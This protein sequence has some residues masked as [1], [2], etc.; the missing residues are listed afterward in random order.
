[1]SI[2]IVD[3]SRD[4][5][6]LLERIL[7]VRGYT[8]I[9]LVE[10]AADAFKHLDMDGTKSAGVDLILMDISMPEMDGIEA[11]R[12]I[13]ENSHLRDIPIIMVTA[14]TE[15]VDLQRSFDAGA[16]DYIKKPVNKIELLARVRSV[17]K[18]KSET[19][20]RKARE[21][22]LLKMTKKLEEANLKLERLSYL[23]GLTGVA[24]RRYFKDSFNKEWRDGA[25]N[26][27]SL[28]LI[29]V[30]I[31]FFKAYNDIYGHYSGDDCLKQV[32]KALSDKL[33]RPRDFVARYGGE[34][35]VVVLPDTKI[36]EATKLAEAMRS[37][38]EALGIKHS[39]SPVSKRVTISL[40]VAVTIPERNLAPEI[41]ITEADKA[42]YQAKRGGR[43]RVKYRIGTLRKCSHD[44]K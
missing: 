37:D 26:N 29:M 38:V 31:D 28:S 10:S 3:D 4:Q 33:K 9:I 12:R 20:R 6:L 8:D 17:L 32:A 21:Q 35:F 11:S 14:K 16:I 23:D 15:A 27:K 13:K 43:N 34:E 19:D 2:L 40:G 42:L 7:K 30:D 5:L 18:L 36:N 22:E 1:M 39:G 41:L 24:N 44:T 25:R